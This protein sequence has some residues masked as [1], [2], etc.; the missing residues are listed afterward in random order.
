MVIFMG[1]IKIKNYGDILFGKIVMI[2]ACIKIIRIVFVIKGVVQLQL[3][4]FCV[5]QLR[6]ILK[7]LTQSI[8]TNQINIIWIG[9]VPLRVDATNHIHIQVGN[10]LCK[11]V[12]GVVGVIFR[13]QQ[14]FFFSRHMKKNN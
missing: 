1:A 10:G 11:R 4:V 8:G 13:S 2:T 5:H 12:E 7:F 3:A 14:I 9:I 6:K